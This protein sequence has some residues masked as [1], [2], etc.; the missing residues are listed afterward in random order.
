MRLLVLLLVLAGCGGGGNGFTIVGNWRNVLVGRDNVGIQT[1][2]A[3]VNGATCGANDT[4]T[5]GGNG[6]F[7]GFAQDVGSFSGNYT[8]Q[9]DTLTATV[10]MVNNQ[11]AQ[12]TFVADIEAE[13]NAFS[14]RESSDPAAF[15]IYQRPSP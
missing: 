10:T 15:Y 12:V 3:N 8:L 2:P 5:F 13:D 14:L 4:I 7:S 1:C 9:G 6:T 11:P